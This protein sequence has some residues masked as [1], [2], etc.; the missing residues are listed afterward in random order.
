MYFFGRRFL[1]VGGLSVANLGN[2]SGGL[3]QL[4]IHDRPA[5]ENNSIIAKGYLITDLNVNYKIR[6]LTIGIGIE[7]I[8]DFACNE[9]QLATESRLR[10]E[11]NSVEETH[12]IPRTPFFFCKGKYYVSVLE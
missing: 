9:I 6:D 2:F 1:N 7:N 5:N 11:P 8:L 12:F 4:Y 10:N 3:Q